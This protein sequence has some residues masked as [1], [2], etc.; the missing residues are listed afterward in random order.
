MA[1]QRVFWS[2]AVD[3]CPSVVTSD[4]QRHAAMLK[5]FRASQYLYEQGQYSPFYGDP[6]LGG[7]GTYGY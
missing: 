4:A 7:Y 6:T 3:Y 1:L 2:A 5:T